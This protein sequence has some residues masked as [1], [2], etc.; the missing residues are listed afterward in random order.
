MGI[1]GSVD[2][3]IVVRDG[4]DDQMMETPQGRAMPLDDEPS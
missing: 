4:V 1:G 2:S 3:R